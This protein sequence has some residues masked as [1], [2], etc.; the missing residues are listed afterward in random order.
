M[1]DRLR[2][3]LVL[4]DFVAAAVAAGRIRILSDGTPWRPLIH[5]A[6]M[7][8]AIDWALDRPA[9]LGA[10]LALN[11]GSDDWNYQVKDLAEAVQ[12]VI[13]G[14]DISISTDAAPDRRSY[15]VDFGL[16]KRLAADHQPR[17]DLTTT[18]AELAEGLRRHRFADQDFHRSAYIRLN[19]LAT[20][21]QT[22]R[23]DDQLRWVAAGPGA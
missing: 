2:L 20:L 19:V 13:P 5:V 15:R 16:F 9:S 7:A 3:D 21:R 11:V 17:Y 6:D 23:L 18:V 22:G 4:N 10:Y 12:R 14:V 1:S 8:R